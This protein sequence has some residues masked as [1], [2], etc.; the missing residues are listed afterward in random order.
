MS[1]AKLLARVFRLDVSV[2][3][4]CGSRMRVIA[5]LTAPAAIRRCL[6][7]IGLSWRAPPIAPARADP[8]PVVDYVA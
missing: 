7:G 6:Q 8:Q 5:A 3:P 2:C 1:W 4:D